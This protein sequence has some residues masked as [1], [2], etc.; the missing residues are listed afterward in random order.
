MAR[1]QPGERGSVAL[2]RHLD[3]ALRRL[4]AETAP[5]VVTGVGVDLVEIAAF[6]ALP[7]A[8]HAAFYALTFTPDE[9]AY[10]RGHVAPAQ[11]FAARFAAKEA[12]MKACGAWVA[13]MP[14]Q[15]EIMRASTG[16]PLVRLHVAPT[17]GSQPRVHV[18]IG[19]SETIAFAVA[20]AVRREGPFAPDAV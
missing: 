4:S 19:H 6:E 14:A 16:A 8:E 10:C 18:S 15:V 5:G 1:Q 9:I 7:L 3:E 20:L 11:H 17:L 2:A 12:V 13:L